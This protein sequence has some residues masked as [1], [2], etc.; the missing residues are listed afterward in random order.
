MK[1]ISWL[2]LTLAIGAVVGVAATLIR[3][4]TR[5]PRAWD[6][7]ELAAYRTGEAAR[8]SEQIDARRHLVLSRLLAKGQI[9]NALLRGEMTLDQAVNHFRQLIERDPAAVAAMRSQYGRAGDEIYYRN[10]LDFA[11][12]EARYR[13]DRGSTVMPLLEAEVSRRFPPAGAAELPVR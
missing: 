2:K 7:E 8:Q 9:V 5:P 3:P 1:G 4:T 6:N 12:G 10:V 11:R 13:P